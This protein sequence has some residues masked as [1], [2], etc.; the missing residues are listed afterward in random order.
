[1][2]E[3]R[4]RVGGLMDARLALIVSRLPPEGS[5]RPP[6]GDQKSQ[7]GKERNPSDRA[8]MAP[9]GKTSKEGAKAGKGK[10]EASFPPPSL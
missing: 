6:L 4:R 1:M 9:Q 5:F 8:N 10:K 3:V 2:E 7:A